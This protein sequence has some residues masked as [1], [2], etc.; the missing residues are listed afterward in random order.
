MGLFYCFIVFDLENSKHPRDVFF[1]KGTRHS[2]TSK[3]VQR[4]PYT[5]LK[6]A[7]ALSNSPNPLHITPLHRHF[8]QMAARPGTSIRQ[9]IP[10]LGAC[11]KSAERRIQKKAKKSTPSAG[12]F[13]R[14]AQTVMI[15]GQKLVKTE[16]FTS[17]TNWKLTFFN[18]GIK[19]VFQ[20]HSLLMIV[21]R[22]I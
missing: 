7:T 9:R 10:F 12:A 5:F 21:L 14:K 3:L 2:Q 4:C 13:L 18:R 8:K 22:G 15:C 6:S 11:R 16:G 19:N 17:Q 20:C 1:K